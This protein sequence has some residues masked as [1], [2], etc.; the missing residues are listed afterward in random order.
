MQG[1]CSGNEE[2]AP[3]PSGLCKQGEKE[4]RERHVTGEA[5]HQGGTLDHTIESVDELKEFNKSVSLPVK[6]IITLSA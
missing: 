5:T 4:T 2:E 3:G 6:D 1:K